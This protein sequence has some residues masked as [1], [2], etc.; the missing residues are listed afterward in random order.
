MYAYAASPVRQDRSQQGQRCP[1]CGQIEWDLWARFCGI[2]GGALGGDALDMGGLAP[3]S[4]SYT[5]PSMGVVVGQP[6]SVQ[7]SAPPSCCCRASCSRASAS[8]WS[9]GRGLLRLLAPCQRPGADSA[10][11]DHPAHE[12]RRPVGPAADSRPAHLLG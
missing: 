6:E 9:T 7:R 5:V 1:A 12:L 2:C 4:T 10:R 8:G 11:A 3:S